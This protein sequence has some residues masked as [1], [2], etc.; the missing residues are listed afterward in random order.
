MEMTVSVDNKRSWQIA[1]EKLQAVNQQKGG[2]DGKCSTTKQ[3]MDD[4]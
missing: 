4:S 1:R 2:K 3:L